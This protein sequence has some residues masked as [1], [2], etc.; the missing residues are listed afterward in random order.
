MDF[1]SFFF[2]FFN[3]GSLIH[4]HTWYKLSFCFQLCSAFF[5]AWLDVAA[6]NLIIQHFAVDTIPVAMYRVKDR[7]WMIR[8]CLA[9]D[10]T[11]SFPNFEITNYHSFYEFSKFHRNFHKFKAFP[12]KFSKISINSQKVQEKRKKLPE[13]HKGSRKITKD[14]NSRHPEKFKVPKLSDFQSWTISRSSNFPL[15]VSIWRVV[16]NFVFVCSC[17]DDISFQPEEFSFLVMTWFAFI[18]ALKKQTKAG[19]IFGIKNSNFFQAYFH[20]ETD[21]LFHVSFFVN[22]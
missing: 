21:A 17:P 14:K 6:F 5:F 1:A 16:A 15:L 3:T 10:S 19:Y 12:K 2:F 11:N 7:A 13:H 8:N 22:C 4:S 9:I 18:R 20:D